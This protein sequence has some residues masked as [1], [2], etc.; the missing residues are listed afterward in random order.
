MSQARRWCRRAV[1]LAAADAASRAAFGVASDVAA[2]RAAARTRGSSRSPS[3]SS[4]TPPA[5]LRP[6]SPR[7]PDSSPPSIGFSHGVRVTV[8][9][10]TRH[11][12]GGV[13]VQLTTR[14]AALSATISLAAL[15]TVGDSTSAHDARP[16]S[17]PPPAVSPGSASDESFYFGDEIGGEAVEGDAAPAR[18]PRV[19]TPASSVD[20][21]YFGGPDAFD[22]EA[23][24]DDWAAPD[25]GGDYCDGDPPP[26]LPP[27]PRTPS[28]P[29]AAPLTLEARA[30]LASRV[31]G[32]SAPATVSASRTRPLDLPR[33]VGHDSPPP[34]PPE[35]LLTWNAAHWA[36]APLVDM[37]PRA[38]ATAQ[39]RYDALDP[40]LRSSSP[41]TYLALSE[42]DGSLADWL[43]DG[44]LCSWLASLG[45]TSVFVPGLAAR[46]GRP[47]GVPTGGA[48]LAWL[49]DEVDVVQRPTPDPQAVVLAGS[50]RRRSA[51]P[52]SPPFVVG[53][54][55]GRHRRGGQLAAVRVVSM[56]ATARL[57]L[58]IAG[59]FNVTPDPSYQR[60]SRR[61]G[62]ADDEFATLVGNGRADDGSDAAS[63]STA[64]LVD[65]RHD[66]AAGEF[67]HVDRSKPLG[68]G[69]F[70]GT[71]TIDHVVVSGPER[72]AW[73]LSSRFF[74]YDTD[75]LVA[76]H[77]LIVVQ[78]RPR[79]LASLSGEYRLPGYHPDKWSRAQR[80]IFF[81]VV[82]RE[83]DLLQRG[84]RI[85]RDGSV[86]PAGTAFVSLGCGHVAIDQIV[87]IYNDA[88]AAAVD[89]LPRSRERCALSRGRGGNGVPG[90]RQQCL[91]VAGILRKLSRARDAHVAAVDRVAAARRPCDA[92][93]AKAAA[94]A[95][96][97]NVWG[98]LD[99][100]S[101]SYVA[102]HD[103]TLHFGLTQF[104]RHGHLSARLMRD[105]LAFAIS[106]LRAS[107]VY[108][109][110]AIAK[111]R[112]A[113]D[114]LIWQGYEEARAARD[115]AARRAAIMKVICGRSYV[116]SRIYG[117][118][119]GD[120][121]S[122]AW[123]SDPAAVRAGIGAIFRAID[124]E[125]LGAGTTPE[126]VAGFHAA[127]V[128]SHGP[129]L[130]GAGQPW[131]FGRSISFDD[132]MHTYTKRLRRGKATSL[133]RIAKEMVEFSPPEVQAALYHA[134]LAVGTPDVDGVRE[135]PA[136]W[137][138]VPVN[139]IDKKSRSDTIGK[140]RDIGLPSQLLKAQGALYLPAYEK[141]M[142]RLLPNFGWTR[143]VAMNGA[144]M[145]GGFALDQ[146]HLLR[147][148]LVGVYGDVRRFF[149]SMDRQYVLLAEA[150]YGLSEDVRVGTMRLYSDACMRYETA[151]GMADFDFSTLHFQGGSIQGCLI[152][153]EKAKI[154]LNSLA[155]ALNLLVDGVRFWNGSSGG[156]H[157]DSVFCADDLLGLNTSWSSTARYVSVLD[158][159]SHVSASHFGIDGY[160]KTVIQALTFDAAGK[161]CDAS[162]P[163][164]MSFTIRGVPIPIAPIDAVY[165]HIGDRRRFDGAQTQAKAHV[166][167][168]LMAWLAGVRRM[169][170]LSPREF[171]ELTNV[172]FAS[173][174]GPYAARLPLSFKD[175]EEMAEKPRRLLY[176]QRFGKAP[177]PANADRYLPPPWKAVPDFGLVT[178]TL[179][180][181]RMT[182]DGWQH[183]AA[184]AAAALHDEFANAL[185]DGI[186]SSLRYAARALL[187]LTCYMWGMRGETPATWRW[188]HLEAVLAR[189]SGWNRSSHGDQIFPM[190]MFILNLIR[191]RNL[192]S[193][194]DRPAYNFVALGDIPDGDPLDPWST[195]HLPMDDDS[196]E[197]FR[198]DLVDPARCAA[199]GI[200][201]REPCW[202]LL[203]AGVV[204]RSHACSIDGSRFLQFHEALLRFPILARERVRSYS[205][206]RTLLAHLRALGVPPVPGESG[207]SAEELW[208][209]S[210][211][212]DASGADGSA[213]PLDDSLLGDLVARLKRGDVAAASEWTLG[214][215]TWARG[216][217][218]RQAVSLPMPQP[219]P[220][221]LNGVPTRYVMPAAANSITVTSSGRPLIAPSIADT[222]KLAWYASQ[223]WS[224]SLD[225]RVL[226]C[227]LGTATSSASVIVQLF[228]RSL[229]LV[230]REYDKRAPILEATHR[231]S[232]AVVQALRRGEPPPPRHLSAEELSW[233]GGPGF[234]VALANETLQQ[235]LV[236]EQWRG[237]PYTAAAVGDGSWEKQTSLVA[238]AT[239]THAGEVLGG[240]VDQRQYPGGHYSNYDAEAAHRVDYMASVTG[241]HVFYAFDSTSPVSHGEK[242]RRSHLRARR[243]AEADEWFSSLL[244]Y[245]DRQRS[246]TY[247]WLRA[248]RGHLLSAAADFLAKCACEDGED[249]TRVPTVLPRQRSLRFYAKA[250]ER[251]LMLSAINLHFAT[252]MLASSRGGV[253]RA[254]TDASDAL[255]HV[256]LRPRSVTSTL[257]TRQDTAPLLCS[258]VYPAGGVDSVGALLRGI[259]CPCGLG[260]QT[261]EHVL[262]VCNLPQVARFRSQLIPSVGALSDALAPLMPV[263]GIHRCATATYSALY[264]ARLP[265]QRAL[266]GCLAFLLGVV[267]DTELKLGFVGA[268]RLASPIL[269]RVD[270][271]IRSA[272][273]TASD[274]VQA[275]AI[276]SRHR[277]AQRSAL[278]SW[279]RQLLFCGIPPDP[280]TG[281]QVVPLS[282]PPSRVIHLRRA[283]DSS[284]NVSDVV[285]FISAV[286]HRHA[287]AARLLAEQAEAAAFASEAALLTVDHSQADPA[288]VATLRV[289]AAA[290]RAVAA[291]RAR[292]AVVL[293]ACRDGVD[294]VHAGEMVDAFR[295]SAARRRAILAAKADTPPTVPQRVL[296]ARMMRA[297]RDDIREALRRIGA[298]HRLHRR[299][300]RAR[301]GIPVAH[302]QVVVE[303]VVRGA[304]TRAGAPV[305]AWPV[306]RVCAHEGPAPRV[307][308]PR[309]GG[310]GSDVAPVAPDRAST[311]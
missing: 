301:D 71:A 291:C 219:T 144:S 167:G 70:Y 302:S 93:E 265:D 2:V 253:V 81:E 252:A 143:G 113:E 194:C 55:Y 151:H 122:L 225:G 117:Y 254:S 221:E 280:D 287:E 5:V 295:V 218:P 23:A 150:W 9:V 227:S 297:V 264:D 156:R 269:V 275:V 90:L 296:N 232:S 11:G 65:L 224:L 248:H 95:A 17:L 38:A 191:L 185:A 201:P 244:V 285:R 268:L 10:A 49:A 74:V 19:S 27:P 245:E 173:I 171:T 132:Y 83:F 257:R 208:R 189:R 47:R 293:A 148:L 130:D 75:G 91:R 112:R 120:D 165:A 60:D 184:L 178:A 3:S 158:E 92:A 161:P 164:D 84:L 24:A 106:H 145:L 303:A 31:V 251:S 288:V 250:S 146:A 270:A 46:G 134:Q 294:E 129:V 223:R 121:A 166:R 54:V 56:R 187:D 196:L 176:R 213:T 298:V 230:L 168:L 180:A 216:L 243:R 273:T 119:E 228:Q 13:V 50:F 272:V 69:D 61:R 152:S 80:G 210:R 212:R 73:A 1:G 263:S 260:F 311:L 271:M 215:A 115:P 76:D 124:D 138:H 181:A 104:Q 67:S 59:D 35:S 21:F 172:G 220:A 97:R 30:A 25:A 37:E 241:E 231:R 128:P 179:D 22:E 18:A 290:D 110:A 149:P 276:Y 105:R 278:R 159:F 202:L 77:E 170:K 125:N 239:L 153:T 262:F 175:A 103:R 108:Y 163:P 43:L 246:V 307:V 68:G 34:A 289:D 240:T 174:I 256:K 87:S 154:F 118:F 100:A 192:I 136:V 114:A 186:D 283:I 63:P 41:P 48:L 42:V 197:L 89:N 44:S 131:T 57:G 86:G 198:G 204:M 255:R 169:A 94:S 85:E 52:S 235:L 139:L 249:T 36:C 203:S 226:R 234:N 267:D 32:D 58:I 33:L 28:P 242:F 140:K 7:P 229:D 127:F 306:V 66:H 99:P 142:P 238:R 300:L 247:W 102:R 133:D 205:A 26:P 126:R 162:P 88:A 155:E 183:L 6:V 258:K 282:F 310:E 82:R 222:A 116:R 12:D 79:T 274:M 111:L 211:A 292:R 206:W 266:P 135:Q 188:D 237:I 284:P 107:V 101:S 29:P 20:S 199:A 200:R 109:S 14:R 217:T 98:L 277:I 286:F 137:Q 53:A 16:P 78:R 51:P 123:V 62:I 96:A 195:H 177:A 190:E 160:K 281:V 259:R 147:F 8:S 157:V 309:G 207:C 209:G 72:G 304:P 214:Y 45:Y 39:R 4:A 40:L 182:G 308:R 193:P 141:V 233:D 279:Y 64:A 236:D 305:L 299:P 15:G 261:R